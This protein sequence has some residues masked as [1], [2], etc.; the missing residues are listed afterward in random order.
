MGNPSAVGGAQNR[1]ERRH[2]AA[3]G[4]ER[5][6]R[7]PAMD[8]HVRLAVGNHEQAA[9]AQ[10]AAHVH[11]KPFGRPERFRLDAQARLFFRCRP[12]CFQTAREMRYFLGQGLEQVRFRQ[13]R[14]RRHPPRPHFF[15]PARRPMDGAQYAPA[16]DQQRDE[17]DEKNLD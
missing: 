13:H 7:F 14:P 11:A 5:F 9:L 8:V 12:S 17:G 1:L 10:F 16:N 4:D 3:G 6:H 15:H 2:Q